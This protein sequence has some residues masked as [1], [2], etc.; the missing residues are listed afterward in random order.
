MSTFITRL[1]FIAPL[2]I[3][4]VAVF[5]VAWLIEAMGDLTSGFSGTE[6]LS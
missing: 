5:M 6:K 1:L 3:L 4:L 2:A